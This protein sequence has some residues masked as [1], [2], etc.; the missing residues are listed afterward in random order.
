V[1]AVIP[2]LE[3]F[4]QMFSEMYD[5]LLTEPQFTTTSQITLRDM[6]RATPHVWGFENPFVPQRRE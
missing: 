4:E 5:E 6:A 3:V 1:S 2:E